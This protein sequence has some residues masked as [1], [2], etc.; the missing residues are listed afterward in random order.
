LAVVLWG[1]L[2]L[3][4]TWGLMLLKI[5]GG[6]GLVSGLLFGLVVGLL[7]VLCLVVRE[8]S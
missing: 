7:S 8:S 4:L 2:G 3:G 1:A 6:R 5:A